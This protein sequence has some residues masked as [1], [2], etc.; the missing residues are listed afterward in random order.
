MLMVVVALGFADAISTII[1]CADCF[2]F[3]IKQVECN[4]QTKQ[5]CNNTLIRV[6]SLLTALT[7][8]VIRA[9]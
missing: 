4:N 8:V 7:K 9:I 3:S 2:M 6:G 5:V 1:Q